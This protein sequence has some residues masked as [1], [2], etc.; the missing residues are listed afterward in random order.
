VTYP[1]IYAIH[2]Q[3]LTIAFGDVISAS[4]NA[5]VIALQKNLEAD[6][7]PGLIE[8]VPSYSSLTVYVE[9]VRIPD[10][11][12]IKELLLQ[13]LASMD[14]PPDKKGD[15]GENDSKNYDN[16]NWVIPVCYDADLGFDLHWVA[17]HLGM[18]PEQVVALHTS[19]TFRVYMI[20]FMP[21]FAYM[22]TLPAE[23]E[24]PRKNIPTATVPAGSV[25]LA[26]KQTGI[27]PAPTPGGWQVIGRTP[28]ALFDKK[29][30][31]ACL[32]KAGDLVQFSSISRTAFDQFT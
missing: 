21:G 26:G 3:A 7:F 24:V 20:G 16:K 10:G 5:R 6:P 32:L 27:Y 18:L 4:I 31:P 9:P 1:R 14:Q 15:D 25:G 13:R 17:A 23:L 2:E 8:L 11:I 12:P 28:L 19:T 30:N 29:R 22:G